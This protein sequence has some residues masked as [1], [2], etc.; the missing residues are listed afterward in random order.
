VVV[1]A[2]RIR[3]TNAAPVRPAR[4]VVLYWCTSAR[5]VRSSPALERAAELARELG[6]PVLVLEALRVGDP[7]ASDRLHAFVLQGMAENARALR[8]RALHHAWLERATGEGEGLLEALAARACA[9]VMDDDPTSALPRSFE[10]AAARLD[11]RVEAVDGSCVVPFR[12]AGKDF[13]TAFAYRRF[14]QEHLPAWI[15]RLPA[16]DPLAGA[17]PPTRAALPAY[18][19]RRWPAADPDALARPERVLAALPIDHRVAPCATRG[20][21]AAA[22]ARLET[23]LARGL[24]RYADARNEPGAEVTSGLSP[25]LHSGHVACFDVLRAVLRREGWTPLR[26]APRASG[27]RAGFWGLSAGTEAF[28][29]QLVT[30]RELGFATCAARPDHREYGSLPEWAR[31]TLAR[32]ARD[33]RPF[34]YDRPE[35]EGART[36]DPLWNAAQRQLLRDGVIHNYLRM[37][38]GKKVLEWSRTPEDALAMLLDLNDTWALDGRDPNSVSGIF[39]CLGRY[40]RPWG[41]ERPIFGTVRYMS[42]ERTARKLDVTSYL[43]RYG[44]GA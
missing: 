2:E 4:E 34:V 22:A 35:L 8:G 36:H 31:A 43:D 33:R 1:S 7:Y 18:V 14:L 10:A 17:P 25:Y 42:S 5:R 23:F 32:H 44:D 12:L 27:K 24:D 26:Q 21:A 20:G 40:D 37:L 39:W 11:V 9:V 13:P 29:D 30:W 3:V 16:E 38:W 15:D 28:L 6:R 41:P 19:L